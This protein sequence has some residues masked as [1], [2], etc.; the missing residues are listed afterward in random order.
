MHERGR[1]GKGENRGG[2]PRRAARA[3]ALGDLATGVLAP[4]VARRAGMSADLLAAWPQMCGHR[5]A[6]YSRP[7]RIKWPRRAHEDDPFEP[8]HLIVACDGPGAVLLQHEADEIV[9]RINAYLGFVAISG[10][11]IVQKPVTRRERSSAQGREPL[12]PQGRARLDRIL[13][14]IGDEAMRA[15]IEKWGEG[16]LAR[17]AAR[18]RSRS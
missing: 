5:H 7:E 1:S 8:G 2:T 12:D 6:Q 14:T 9:A 3:R 13:S 10:L 17:A 16:A 18:K 15:R 4:V 11:R